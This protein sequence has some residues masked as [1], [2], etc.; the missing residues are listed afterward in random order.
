M[1]IRIYSL[2]FADKLSVKN[3][4]FILK[5]FDISLINFGGVFYGGNKNNALSYRK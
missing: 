1:K 2:C 5:L 3:T 4:D